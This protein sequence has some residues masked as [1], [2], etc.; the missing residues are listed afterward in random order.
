M[1]TI[2][3]EK[4]VKTYFEHFNKHDWKALASMYTPTAEFKDPSLGSGIIKQTQQQII[5]KYSELNTI[6]P[7]LNDTVIATYPSGENHIIVEFISTGTAPDNTKFVLPICTIF[8][9]E[10]GKINKDF[11]YFDNFKEE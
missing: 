4:L 9:I 8:T 2:A 1:E 11:T 7:D 3:N 10:N 6:F 5:D